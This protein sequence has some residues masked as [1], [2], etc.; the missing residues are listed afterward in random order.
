MRGDNPKIK[1]WLEKY[2]QKY[3]PH[4]FDNDKNTN[5]VYASYFSIDKK[6][7]S[8]DSTQNFRYADVNGYNFI[9]KNKESLID[10]NNSIKFIWTH[11][12]LKEGWDC[13]NIFQICTLNESF[14]Y[15]KEQEIGRGLR[16]PLMQ[17]GE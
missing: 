5:P 3:A 7:N 11:S 16:L 2:I 9:F 14:S 1:I 8:I 4:K 15:I 6:G 10:Y 12:A 13:P 17:N